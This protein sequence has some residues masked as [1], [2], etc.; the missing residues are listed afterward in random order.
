[1]S[2]TQPEMESLKT[3]LKSTWMAGDFGQVAKVIE[4][5]ATEFIDR[6]NLNCQ[7]V[8]AASP[9]ACVGARRVGIPA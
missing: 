6:L 8:P 3:R 7:S 1:M 2:T 5:S 4:D 9:T